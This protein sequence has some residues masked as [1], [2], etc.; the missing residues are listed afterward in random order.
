MSALALLRFCAAA[1]I[2][3]ALPD[4]AGANDP[5]PI[6]PDAPVIE[7]ASPQDGAAYPAGARVLVGFGCTSETSFVVSCEGTQPLGSWLDTASAGT[8]T[9]SVTAV[10]YDGRRATATATATYTVST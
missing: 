2:C 3:L 9:L 7:I 5:A 1:G 4:T 6:D 8:K 10:D